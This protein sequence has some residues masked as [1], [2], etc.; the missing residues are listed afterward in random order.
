MK[1]RAYLT[2]TLDRDETITERVSRFAKEVDRV[3]KTVWAWLSGDNRPQGTMITEIK[4]L[5]DGS[6]REKDWF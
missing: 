1:L 4:N 6:V 2:K 3:D 5:T